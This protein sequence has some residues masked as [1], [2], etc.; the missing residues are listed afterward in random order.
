MVLKECFPLRLMGQG[1]LHHR[2]LFFPPPRSPRSPPHTGRVPI[3]AFS[4][5][6][7]SEIVVSGD[8]STSATSPPAAR[9]RGCD[10][11]LGCRRGTGGSD[12]I[13]ALGELAPSDAWLL[14]ERIAF[15]PHGMTT[16]RSSEVYLCDHCLEPGSHCGSI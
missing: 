16:S 8:A 11:N 4:C 6:F 12:L 3:A 7:N 13:E 9:S 14:G 2:S 5:S 10:R 1:T 15:D